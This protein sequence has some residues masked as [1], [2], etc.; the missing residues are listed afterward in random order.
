M[1]KKSSRLKVSLDGDRIAYCTVDHSGNRTGKVRKWRVGVRSNLP[2]ALFFLMLQTIRK[3][4]RLLDKDEKDFAV[5]KEA[6][7]R[8][9]RRA[10][11]ACGCEPCCSGRADIAWRVD[12]KLLASFQVHDSDLDRHRL[13]VLLKSKAVFRLVLITKG[14]GYLQ[15]APQVTNARKRSQ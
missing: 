5:T 6:V 7:V 8:G 9:L 10:A 15:I 13:N 4:V 11:K 1:A 12:G 2:R 3:E 14:K